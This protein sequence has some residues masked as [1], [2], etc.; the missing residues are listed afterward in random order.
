[1]QPGTEGTSFLVV[2]LGGATGTPAG[3]GDGCQRLWVKW[4]A[5]ERILNGRRCG[6]GTE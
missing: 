1:M 2:R 3:L 5:Y 4:A 6:S